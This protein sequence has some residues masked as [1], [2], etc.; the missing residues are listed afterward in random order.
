MV[1]S[2]ATIREMT[3]IVSIAAHSCLP[4]FQARGGFGAPSFSVD[5]AD[6]ISGS[7]ECNFELAVPFC[8][9]WE[10][11]EEEEGVDEGDLSCLTAKWLKMSG[12]KSMVGTSGYSFA[13]AFALEP[14][15]TRVQQDS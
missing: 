14:W 11:E 13:F 9:N 12:L 6:S 10:D 5:P 3:A 7:G 2:R 4:G 1:A 8:S 15:P